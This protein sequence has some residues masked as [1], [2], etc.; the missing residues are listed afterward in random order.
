M[1]RASE[2][3]RQRKVQCGSCG[4]TA[5]QTRSWME[6]GLLTCPCGGQL[7][8]TSAADQAFIGLITAADMSQRD[9]N[10]ICRENGW[11]V[12]LNQGQMTQALNKGR[13][14]ASTL[15]ERASKPQCAYPGCGQWVSA[16]HE[17]CSEHEHVAELAL[18]GAMPF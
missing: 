9:W 4:N 14:V 5:R 17:H 11:P 16:G 12:V 1:K 8:P 6:Q 3:C 2:T 13:K 18:A 10:A 15:A 7:E